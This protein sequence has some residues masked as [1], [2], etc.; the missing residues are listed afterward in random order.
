MAIQTPTVGTL[1]SERVMYV[2]RV[3]TPTDSESCYLAP[4]PEQ[5][6]AK[7]WRLVTRPDE[8]DWSPVPELWSLRGRVGSFVGKRA[9][10]LLRDGLLG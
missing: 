5:A 2:L 6:L 4:P 9:L 3:Y 10:L 1:A 8:G 7:A